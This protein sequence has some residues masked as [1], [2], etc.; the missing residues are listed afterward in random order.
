MCTSANRTHRT[1]IAATS[2][3]ALSLAA[4]AMAKPAKALTQADIHNMIMAEAQKLVAL[5]KAENDASEA[6]KQAQ[7]DALQAQVR[8]LADQLQTLQT[9]SQA[10]SQTLAAV[11]APK[12]APAAPAA[13]TVAA[14]LKNGSPV[15]ASSDGA[16][17][18]NVKGLFQADAATYSQDD[19]LP[20]AVSA[21]DLNSG[22]NIRRARV[23]FNGKMFSDF[24]YN[25]TFDFG[26]AGAEDV[27]R[28]HEAWIQYSG[29]KSAK[30]RVG[31]FSPSLGLADAA[32]QGG[33]PFLERPVSAEIARNF[34][35]GD[36]RMGVTAFNASDRYLWAV[37]ITGNTVS[38]LNTAASSFNT[39]NNDEQLGVT[40]RI[41]GTPIKGKNSLVHI[42]LN[43]SAIINPAD[44]GASAT[45]RYPVQLRDRPEL[46]VDGTRLIDTGAINADS[47]AATGFEL[48]AQY[49]NLFLQGEAFDYRIQ[50]LN[51]AT[52]VT[53]PKFTGWYVE[54]GWVLTGENRKYN[55]QT[56][57][58]DGVTPAHNFD[59]KSGH[60]GAFEL[61][62]RYSTLDLNYHA[63]A[64]LTADRVLG[65]QQD[66]TALGLDWQLT[67]T[68]RF[69]FQGQSV[70]VNR[71]NAAGDQIGQ[72]YTT[73]AVR[74]QFG[75]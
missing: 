38:S 70:E 3:M 31:E 12:P 71:V 59:P 5:Q 47:A 13:P 66:I 29:F 56:A 18:F 67:P 15:L 74:S 73:F 68:V 65:G 9:Q 24:D 4:P 44:N 17:T 34:A 19:N 46:R 49:K 1:L 69:I 62:A 36:T 14:T 53:D 21:R 41:A 43:Y 6:R 33:S 22:S 72:D 52:G 11:T 42:G 2:L 30:F 35:G 26:G 25:L 57:A 37:A 28:V 20:S 32:S 8:S 55:T 10:Q 58:F 50:R 23:I 61:V 54:G 39:V 7:I 64:T 48:G 40:A 27:G 63:D 60:W 51:A 45:T 16:F 75:F